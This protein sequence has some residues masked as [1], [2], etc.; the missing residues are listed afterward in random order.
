MSITSARKAVLALLLLALP[1]IGFAQGFDAAGTRAAGMSGAFVAVTDDASAAYWNPAG[2]ASGSF[3]SLAIDRLTSSADPRGGAPAGSQSGFMI[4]L[5]AP[6]LGL[7]YYRLRGTTLHAPTAEVP[8]GRNDAGTADIRLSTLVS[9]HVGAT[10]VQSLAEGI[11]VGATL[12]LVRGIAAD[13]MVAAGDRGD[14][15]DEAVDLTGKA[16]NRFDADLGIMATVG[17]IRAGLTVRNLTEPSFESAGSGEE[18][19]LER[20]ARAG[21]AVSPLEGWTLA[22]DLDLLRATGANGLERRDFALGAE[23]RVARR[24][25]VRAG[26]RLDTTGDGPGGRRATASLGASYAVSGGFL[27]DG[28]ATLGSKWGGRGW[29]ISGRFVY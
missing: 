13:G 12:K 5:G 14:L 10:L 6:A 15:L 22:A 27:I 1:G 20:Q 9:H 28:Q 23:G 4:A 8:D 21:V 17:R 26:T 18:L 7:S 25:F 3:F 11:A 2:F 24:A 16:S 19:N 29:G